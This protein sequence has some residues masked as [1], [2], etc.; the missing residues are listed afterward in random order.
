MQMLETEWDE[1]KIL[2]LLEGLQVN[3]VVFDVD[4]CVIGRVTEFEPFACA[5]RPNA[6][7]T[8]QLLHSKNFRI[9]LWSA[10]GKEHC[11]NVVKFQKMEDI[12]ENT[13]RKAEYPMQFNDVVEVLGFK[14]DMT[15]DND[16]SE[17]VEGIPFIECSTFWGIPGIDV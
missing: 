10:G 7:E 2:H 1:E 8:L 16:K 9:F 12:I 13:F 14:P 5:M 6:K 11:D 3:T 4:N 15:I 17:Q